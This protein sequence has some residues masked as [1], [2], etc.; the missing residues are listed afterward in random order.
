M[1]G[2]G[3]TGQQYLQMS[4][5]TKLA[6]EKGFLVIY[7]T[8]THDNHVRYPQDPRVP[9]PLRGK[10]SIIIFKVLGCC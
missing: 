1:H 4:G 6:D 2:C 9:I 8:T 5:Y 10:Y 3:G 7:P